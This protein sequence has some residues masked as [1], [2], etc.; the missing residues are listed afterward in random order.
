M[1]A[2]QQ[3]TDYLSVDSPHTQQPPHY[4]VQQNQQG[5]PGYANMVTPDPR[6]G[7]QVSGSHGAPSV[8]QQGGYAQ[9]AQIASGSAA[10]MRRAVEMRQAGGGRQAASKPAPQ[11]ATGKVGGSKDDSQLMTK[12][13]GYSRERRR[14]KVDY[15]P[16]TLKEYNETKPD[17]YAALGSLGADLDNP[18]LAA[19][20][21]R[22]ARAKDYA[23]GVWDVARIQRKLSG[24]RRKDGPQSAPAA[25]SR[26]RGLA[27]QEPPQQ[28]QEWGIPGGADVEQRLQQRNKAMEYAANVPKP[29]PKREPRP[30]A[31]APA[32]AAA[33][34]DDDDPASASARYLSQLQQ[35][36]EA[37]QAAV[38]AI[39]MEIG[40]LKV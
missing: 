33:D 29:K 8:M 32:A 35:E 34:D 3:G 7:Q 9:A 30:E 13:G 31:T 25:A 24:D 1:P 40:T 18:E 19:K 14:P 5:M 23:R 17:R 6:L 4:N 37:Q 2:P 20:R 11:Y 39:R 12:T 21:E 22:A 36:H 16:R 27:Q 38:E 10:E 28:K 26:R 15:I